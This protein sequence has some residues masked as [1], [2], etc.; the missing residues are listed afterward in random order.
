MD[1]KEKRARRQAIE[2][3]IAAQRK[4]AGL[5]QAEVAERL[6]VSNDA[7]SRFERGNIVPSAIRLFELVEIF[8]CDAGVLLN[9]AGGR[10]QDNARHIEMLPAPL[11]EKQRQEVVAIVAQLAA[12]LAQKN[13]E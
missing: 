3:A 9:G 2:R 11:S 12:L 6:D 1:D 4:L 10:V 8:G 13:R 7:V 5:T